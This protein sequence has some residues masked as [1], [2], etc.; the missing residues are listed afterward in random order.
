MVRFTWQTKEIICLRSSLLNL[1]LMPFSSSTLKFSVTNGI[2][3]SSLRPDIHASKVLTGLSTF[4]NIVAIRRTP[5]ARI[6]SKGVRTSLLKASVAFRR[7]SSNLFFASRIA[8]SISLRLFRF[9]FLSSSVK[10]NSFS[11][12]PEDLSGSS[13]IWE[14]AFNPFSS[15]L[16]WSQK[17]VVWEAIDQN[18][19]DQDAASFSASGFAFSLL[20]SKFS[21]FTFLTFPTSTG[22]AFK[23]PMPQVFVSIALLRKTSPSLKKEIL[24]P[25]SFFA[26]ASSFEFTLSISSTIQFFNFSFVTSP[27]FSLS[28]AAFRPFFMRNPRVPFKT[29]VTIADITCCC[30]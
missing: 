25:R 8:S 3:C 26:I 10:D 27:S 11:S 19:L 14:A 2:E 7:A 17:P 6:R 28:T 29:V 12:A 13:V 22:L 15:S 18:N 24:A 30:F 21:S 5:M 16:P 1:D 20:S 23:L 4:S 9:T